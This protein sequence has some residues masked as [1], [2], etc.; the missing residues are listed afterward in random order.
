MARRLAFVVWWLGISIPGLIATSL[1]V[2]VFKDWESGMRLMRMVFF[3]MLL[4]IAMF[5]SVAFVLGGSFW[6]PPRWRGE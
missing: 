3:P 4:W 1:V 5:W 6:R 2:W